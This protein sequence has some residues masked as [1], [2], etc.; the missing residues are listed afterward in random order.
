MAENANKRNIP[1]KLGDFSVI[2]TEFSSIR[3]RFDSEMKK[4]EEEMARFRS[5][6]MNRESNFFES[7]FSSKKVATSSTTS[8]A[9]SSL[10]QPQAQSAS[11]ISSPLIQEDGDNKVLKLRFD[12]SQYAPEEIVVKTVD[13]KLLVH[14]THEEKTDTKSVYREYNREFLLPKG[15]NPELIKSSLS[16]DG[17]LTVDAPL[18]PQALTAGETMIPIA[19]N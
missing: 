10:K 7:T 5:D 18:P 1:I 16:K 4:M 14:A 8:N 13:N 2:D 6:L 3:E 19:H 17:V 12:V 15:C 11:D 9:G